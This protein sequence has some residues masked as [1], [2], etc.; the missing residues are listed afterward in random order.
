[1]K[2][3][4]RT[5]AGLAVFAAGG[6]L[7]LSAPLLI[8]VPNAFS[9]G[10]YLVFPPP[11]Y[12]LRWFDAFLESRLW[13]NA[14]V[15]SVVVAAASTAIATVLGTAAALGLGAWPYRGRFAVM[16]ALVSPLLTPVVI[17]G[18]AA[19]QFFLTVNLYGSLLSLMLAH[20]VLGLPY[21]VIAVAASL[22]Q[23]D[24]R[25]GRAA[26][27]LGAGSIRTF[28]EVTLPLILPGVAAGAVLAFI[29]S[30][31][32][33]VVASFLTG[34]RTATLPMRMFQ[35]ASSEFD[36]TIA[37]ASTMLIGLAILMLALTAIIERGQRR[38]R[39]TKA[40]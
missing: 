4:S 28:M 20:S 6:L 12:S 32:D 36:P 10:A 8:V 11:G 1:M 30:F 25:M 14:V 22:N 9:D 35:A 40:E 29:I 24:P 39:R 19:Y 38:F 31:D 5:D 16:L 21:V 23:L 15:T 26:H 18:I 13:V 17:I 27:S 3:W 2:R 34:V 37:V 33:V 7:F